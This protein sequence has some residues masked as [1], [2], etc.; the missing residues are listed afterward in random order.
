M[1]FAFGTFGTDKFWSRTVP[2][3]MPMFLRSLTTC[4]SIVDPLKS[5]GGFLAC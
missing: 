2:P 1:D 4:R 3:R 5:H